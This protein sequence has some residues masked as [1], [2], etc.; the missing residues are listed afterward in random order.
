MAE[1]MVQTVYNAQ[2]KVPWHWPVPGY[3]VTKAMGSGLFL[4]LSL[5]AGLNLFPLDAVTAI[6][7]YQ[8]QRPAP[9]PA[10][11]RPPRVEKR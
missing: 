1:H 2:H 10:S 8:A 7:G 11:A 4:L 3:L 5:G 6:H 9:E